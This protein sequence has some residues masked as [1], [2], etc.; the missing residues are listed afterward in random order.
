M[1]NATEVLRKEHKGI[2]K[3]LDVTEEVARRLAAGQ[4]VAPEVLTNLLEFF[5][6]FADRCHHGKEEDLLFPRLQEKGMPRAGGPIGVM[7]AEHDQ[8]RSLVKQMAEAAEAYKSG[9]TG[10]G[11]RWAEAARG[12][13]TLLRGHID[14]ENNVLFVMAERMLTPAEQKELAEEFERVEVEK[15]GTGTHE[16]LHGLMDKMV[17]EFLAKR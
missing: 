10:S 12:Y 4:Q 16:R 9:A 17:D 15:M 2:L 8:G 11:S 5:R 7:L 1:E 3:M 13:C 6:L 14:K